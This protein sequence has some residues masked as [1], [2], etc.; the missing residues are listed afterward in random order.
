MPA[1]QFTITLQD[2]DTGETRTV[3]TGR[4]LVRAEPCPRL[5]CGGSMLPATDQVAFGVW[6]TEAHCSLCG[7]SDRGPAKHRQPIED[8]YEGRHGWRGRSRG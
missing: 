4:R 2:G 3:T 7:R 6:V 1:V 8:R 5:I